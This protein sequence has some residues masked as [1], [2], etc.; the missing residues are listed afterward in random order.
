MPK[1]AVMLLAVA[2]LGLASCGAGPDVASDRAAEKAESAAPAR[3]APNDPIH[4]GA[5]SAP[6][7]PPGTPRLNTEIQL[8][9]EVWANWSGVRV[10]V[11]DT[12]TKTSTTY[13]VLFSE[14]ME[15]GDSG[16][17]LEAIVFIPDFVMDESGISTRTAEPNNPAARVV[18]T[19]EGSEPYE[20]WLFAVMPE[21]HP[22]PHPRYQVLLEEGIPAD[23]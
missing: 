9:D 2:S 16:L 22:F 7:M 17:E 4:G 14:T 5:E 6:G 3:I 15:L 21:I 12:L 8:P 11:E 1:I 20:G 18:I 23:S 13:D 19:E 10:R